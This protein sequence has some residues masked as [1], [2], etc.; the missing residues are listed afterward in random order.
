[1]FFSGTIFLYA[2]YVLVVVVH[3]GLFHTRWG[4]RV[5]SVGEHPRA[6]DTVGINVRRTRFR[7]VLHRRR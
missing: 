7:A 4:L 3:F 1:M 5:R 2:T 6:A